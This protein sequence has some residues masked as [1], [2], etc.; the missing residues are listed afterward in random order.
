MEKLALLACLALAV[1]L[2]EYAAG[3]ISWVAQNPTLWTKEL[4]YLPIVLIV[5]FAFLIPKIR[6]HL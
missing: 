3:I 2:N 4:G 5:A 6:K 1:T